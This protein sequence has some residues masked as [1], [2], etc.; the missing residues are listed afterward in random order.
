VVD[1]FSSKLDLPEALETVETI[2]ANHM[3]MARCSDKSD[4]HY[5]AILG[6]LKRFVRSCQADRDRTGTQLTTAVT[7]T[8]NGQATVMELGTNESMSSS[9]F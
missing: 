3:Q 4:E 8:D 2:N 7:T 6:I 5:R 1:D 9:Q